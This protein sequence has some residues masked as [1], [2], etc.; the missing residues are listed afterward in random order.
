ML[1]I[2]HGILLS[3][4]Q[5]FYCILKCVAHFL[6]QQG[7]TEHHITIIIMVMFYHSRNDGFHGVL[8]VLS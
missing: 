6:N 5:C 8:L 7:V 1:R 4:L 3:S 2:V